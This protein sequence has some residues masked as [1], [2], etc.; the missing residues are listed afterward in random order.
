MQLRTP[1]CIVYVSYL[2]TCSKVLCQFLK[3][4]CP[5]FQQQLTFSVAEIGFMHIFE[6]FFSTGSFGCLCT[7]VFFS[8]VYIESQHMK[9]HHDNGLR[10]YSV[11]LKRFFRLKQGDLLKG[12]V[13]CLVRRVRIKPINVWTLKEPLLFFSFQ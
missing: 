2:L 12:I 3:P 13:I 6:L 1:A 5:S 4:P 11:K 8:L 10:G 7:L 9:I